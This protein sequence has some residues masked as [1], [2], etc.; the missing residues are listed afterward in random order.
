MATEVDIV[1][2][3]LAHLGDPGTVASI[4]PPEGSV[5]AAKAAIFYPI[6]RD[7][8]QSIYPWNF[9]TRRT[10]PAT[11]TSETTS[12]A[13]A[14]AIPSE[15][16]TIFSVLPEDTTN[17]YVGSLNGIPSEVLLLNDL[18]NVVTGIL[19]QN[20]AR[21]VLGDKQDVI[22]TNVEN[23]I[24]RYSIKVIDTSKFS[25]PF[26]LAISRMLASYLAGPLIKGKRGTDMALKQYQL[27][28]AEMGVAKVHDANQSKQTL[29]YKPMWMRDR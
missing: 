2:L 29:K 21:E 25:A 22:Y 1:N 14:Y 7:L 4:D 27:F 11:L 17:D 19:P 6:A 10:A 26:V 12:Y 16:L 15:A 20:Y 24:V 5:Q 18:E 28:L 3:A 9:N 23:A 8:L 13:Y